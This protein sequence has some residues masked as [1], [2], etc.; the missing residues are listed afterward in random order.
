MRA[1]S[2]RTAPRFEP[3]P[4]II[5]KYFDLT[6][7]QKEKFRRMGPVYAELNARVN[8]ISRKDFPRFYLHH[9][10][11]SLAIAK[12]VRFLP[13]ARILDAGTGGGFPGI[14][15]AVMFPQTRFHLVDSIGKK[16]RAVK[17]AVRRLELPNVTV[18]QTRLENHRDR[19]DFIVSRAVTRMDQ[20]YR[21]TAKNI[22]PRSRHDI[23][24]GILYLKGGDLTEEL[25][26]FPEARVI[27][28]S[29]Y[30]EEPFFETKKLVY[31]PVV[32]PPSS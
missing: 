21:W 32:N 5:E 10:L 19:Y 30:F 9:V 13:E 31:L 22:S 25:A 4:E 27:P 2:H 20:F 26:P 24:N 7:E 1:Q 11:H 28:L 12:F 15:L 6:E 17:E 29:R 8:L 18:E 14:P 16:V 23:P 3:G